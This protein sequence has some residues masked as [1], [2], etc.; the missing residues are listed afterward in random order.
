MKAP[1]R[2]ALVLTHPAN[3]SA[4]PGPVIGHYV[5]GRDLIR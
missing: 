3:D 5:K 4:N 1:L 2:G